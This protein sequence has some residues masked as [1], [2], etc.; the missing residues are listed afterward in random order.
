MEI[1]SKHIKGRKK[2]LIL[3]V[4]LPAIIFLAFMLVISILMI[5]GNSENFFGAVILA[6]TVWA[7][8]AFYSLIFSIIYSF[9]LEFWI[10]KIRSSVFIYLLCGFWAELVLYILFDSVILLAFLTIY[11]STAILRRNYLDSNFE[12]PDLES[13]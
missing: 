9:T 13:Q 2:R 1:D 11:L 7:Y 8:L 3:G 5:L 4:F 12:Y 10:Q 6:I